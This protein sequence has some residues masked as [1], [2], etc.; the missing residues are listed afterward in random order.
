MQLVWSSVVQLLG[1]LVPPDKKVS[2]NT[3]LS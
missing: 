1:A 3:I 2:G